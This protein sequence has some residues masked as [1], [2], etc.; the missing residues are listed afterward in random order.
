[1]KKIITSLLVILFSSFTLYAGNRQ[2]TGKESAS[3]SWE[4]I[5]I[6]GH[7]LA[8][9]CILVNI[10]SV[11]LPAPA[12]RCNSWE[13]TIEEEPSKK[14][15]ARVKKAITTINKRD[16]SVTFDL[17]SRELDTSGS[18]TEC[19]LIELSQKLNAKKFK[20]FIAHHLKS[21]FMG[22]NQMNARIIHIQICKAQYEPK[23]TNAEPWNA[24]VADV[25]NNA[26]KESL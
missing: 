8:A 3:S 1:M 13:M 24:F 6:Q 23:I 4:N 15:I 9:L 16:R 18:Y 5:P 11:F 22:H 21:R 12:D 14:H 20:K 7:S 19:P 2:S 25:K 26:P 10:K 17:L